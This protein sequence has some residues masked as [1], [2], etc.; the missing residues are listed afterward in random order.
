MIT[1]R[2]DLINIGLTSLI[3]KVY[4]QLTAL[5][6]SWFC[7]KRLRDKEREIKTNKIR[8]RDRKR[9]R[10]IGSVANREI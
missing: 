2:S 7:P 4:Y 5:D 1:N 9:E 3:N 10:N 6:T 8:E